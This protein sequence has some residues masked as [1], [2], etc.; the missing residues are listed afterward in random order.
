M[1]L[2]EG[3]YA[4]KGNVAGETSHEYSGKVTITKAGETYNLLW[5]IPPN[6]K[7]EGVAYFDNG[8]L[9]VSY[10]DLGN[11][12]AGVVQY[13]RVTYGELEGPWRS[14]HSPV[15]SGRETLTFERAP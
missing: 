12:D 10:H 15:T 3:T 11:G 5:D 9:S 14:L 6:Q 4:L 13:K 8:I 7:Q 1:P 2:R